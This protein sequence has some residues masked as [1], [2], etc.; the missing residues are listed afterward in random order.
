[1]KRELIHINL[2]ED[3]TI[4]CILYIE[5]NNKKYSLV[6]HSGKIGNK[7]VKK[8]LWDNDSYGA[9]KD[10]FWERYNQRKLEHFKDKSEVLGNLNKLFGYESY[11]CD[12]CGKFIGET[13]YKKIESY[14]SSKDF[15]KIDEFENVK[16]KVLCFDCQNKYGILEKEKK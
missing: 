16:D 12:D 14:L 5:K 3:I 13:L 4:F 6:E 15:S 7:G 8:I 10:R 1:M 11:C 2:T 9:C